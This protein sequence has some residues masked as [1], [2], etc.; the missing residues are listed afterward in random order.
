MLELSTSNTAR[1]LRALSAQLRKS[2]DAK[3]IR[4]KLNKGLR[5]GTK[6]ALTATKKAAL[7]LP[8][9]G[10]SRTNLRKNMAAA[11]GTQVRASGRDPGVRVRIARKRLEKTNQASLAK[12]TNIGRWRHPVHARPGRPRVWVTQEST[13]GWF[14]KA[15]QYSARPVRRELKAVLDGIEKELT[16]H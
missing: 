9:T 5:E 7:N 11:S 16:Q 1:D 14:D 4:K 15:N 8:S 3:T 13:P 2:G 6:P 12:V 10:K